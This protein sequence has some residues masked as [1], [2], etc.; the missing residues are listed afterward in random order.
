MAYRAAT[1]GFRNQRL[2][3]MISLVSQLK[4]K[5]FLTYSS[6][7]RLAFEINIQHTHTE[8]LRKTYKKTS[9]VLCVLGFVSVKLVTDNVK[10]DY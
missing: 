5:A 2:S 3:E 8:T 9:N 7:S 4:L 1:Y 10:I 6:S